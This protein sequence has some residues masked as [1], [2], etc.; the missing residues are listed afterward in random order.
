[1]VKKYLLITF[2]FLISI[3]IFSQDSI[4]ASNNVIQDEVKAQRSDL[5][6]SERIDNAFRPA[7]DFINSILFWDPFTAIGV[8]DPVVYD[9]FGRPIIDSDGNPVE[10]RLPLIVFWLIFGAITFTVFMRFINIRGFKHAIQLV[11]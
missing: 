2:L 1:M 5:T 8:Y 4:R 7:V 6:V 9:E 3:S 10:S 11:Q